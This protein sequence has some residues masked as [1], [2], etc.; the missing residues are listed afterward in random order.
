[1][2]GQQK[3]YRR[4]KTKEAG[5]RHQPIAFACVVSTMLTLGA[6]LVEG[7]GISQASE[8][9]RDAAATYQEADTSESVSGLIFADGFE[10]G[11]TSF[12]VEGECLSTLIMPTAVTE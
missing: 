4:G 6:C 11:D 9:G 2:V 3:Q 1:M 7:P 10:S 12:W 5:M 8:L